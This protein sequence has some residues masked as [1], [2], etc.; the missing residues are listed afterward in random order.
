MIRPLAY[1]QDLKHI[2]TSLQ[3]I[4]SRIEELLQ[5]REEYL[6]KG[7]DLCRGSIEE[8]GIMDTLSSIDEGI[9]KQINQ[10]VKIQLKHG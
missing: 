5:L 7:V 6:A 3:T 9:V 10:G 1:C 4:D 8:R 2:Q